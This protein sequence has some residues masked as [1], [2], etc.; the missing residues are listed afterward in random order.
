[1]SVIR[2]PLLLEF[3]QITED[4]LAALNAISPYLWFYITGSQY[5]ILR[6]LDLEN[7]LAVASGGIDNYLVYRADKMSDPDNMPNFGDI[8][9]EI[10]PYTIEGDM[11]RYVQDKS[12]YSEVF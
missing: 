12:P 2:R 10:H 7:A 3:I 4:N 11:T 5:T 8:I 9:D 1:M 6:G